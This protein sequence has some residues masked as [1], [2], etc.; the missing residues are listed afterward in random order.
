MSQYL[1]D[2]RWVPNDQSYNFVFG[3]PFGVGYNSAIPMNEAH[4]GFQNYKCV[5]SKSHV[6]GST[7]Y[8]TTEAKCVALDSR[9]RC[10]NG[11][12]DLNAV[13]Y[14]QAGNFYSNFRR[15]MKV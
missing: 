3:A 8:A 10:E 12:T 14:Q 7:T 13:N 15:R 2:C 6:Y 11:N 9:Q 1:S 5:P 4:L